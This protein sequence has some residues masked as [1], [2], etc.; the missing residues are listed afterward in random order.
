LGVVPRGIDREICEVLHST[1]MGCDQDYHSLLAQAT[2]V[3]LA[4]GW[5]GSMLA[6][7]HRTSCLYP[8]QFSVRLTW[9]F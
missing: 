7:E 3:S 2:K 6:T 4:D 1:H 5:G 9:G 8:F